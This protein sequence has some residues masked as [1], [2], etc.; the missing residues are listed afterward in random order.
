MPCIRL[1]RRWAALLV[2]LVTACTGC[3]TGTK[4]TA[5]S[6]I[7]SPKVSITASSTTFPTSVSSDNIQQFTPITENT[8][9]AAFDSNLSTFVVRTVDSGTHWKNVTPPINGANLSGAT[10]FFLDSDVAWATPQ[11]VSD[12]QSPEPVYRTLDGG[13]S[14]QRL[15]MVPSGCQLDFVDQV[16][17]WCT[18]TGAAAG[19]ATVWIYQTLD[20][21][22]TWVLVSH[23]GLYG[24]GSTPD[25]LPYACDKTITFTSA[26]IGWASSDCDSGSS[27]FYMSSDG[28]SQWEAQS[29]LSGDEIGVPVVTGT[30]VA[31]TVDTGTSTEVSTSSD[32]GK[33][34]KLQPVPGSTQYE[35]VD[36]IDPTHWIA[37]DGTR[38]MATDD[39][40]DN[41]SSWRP[42]VDLK[43]SEGTAL[44][45]DFL[46]PLL[47]W[48]VPD[49]NGGRLSWTTDGGATWRGVPS[50]PA[51]S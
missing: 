30:G 36:L 15:G 32:G 41:W 2:L 50:P 8:W 40:G 42:T 13:T 31:L 19:S 11:G 29:P 1:C 46:S 28:G 33:T 37:T 9:W 18:I 47:G 21:G 51:Q 24:Q 6:A 12:S 45:L 25:S 43:N 38:M 48:A 20:G 17:G 23:T 16:H 27:Y 34:W 39:A 4:A 7:S 35:S 10:V 3:T 26:T 14:W 49:G 44:S 5:H 22:S